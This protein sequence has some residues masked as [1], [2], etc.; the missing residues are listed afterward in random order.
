MTAPSLA[1]LLVRILGAGL[2]LAPAC[3]N[4]TPETHPREGI[5]GLPGP[6]A[7]GSGGSGG[8]GVGGSGVGGSGGEGTGGNPGT[9]GGPHVASCSASGESCAVT[10]CCQVGYEMC[11]GQGSGRFCAHADRPPTFGGACNGPASST[12]PGVSLELPDDRC[13]YTLAEV[14]AGISIKYQV[15]VAQPLEMVHPQPTDAGRCQRPDASGL[16]VGFDIQGLDGSYCLCDTGPC[17]SPP[18]TTAPRAGRYDASITWDG[19]RWYG[20]SDTSN[21]EGLPFAP[22]FYTLSLVSSGTIGGSG[23]ISTDASTDAGVSYAISATR[24]IT[25]TP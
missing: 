12:L 10:G 19:R 25:I 11:L 6:G 7:G 14:A 15:V 3:T 16:I 18:V 13:S 21:P 20:P 17:F 5:G 1:R 9:G 23:Q 4:Q 24:H 8:S 22:G 2:A